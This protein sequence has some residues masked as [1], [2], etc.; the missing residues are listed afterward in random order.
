MRAMARAVTVPGNGGT[1]RPSLELSGPKLARALESLVFMVSLDIYLNE[2]SRHANVFLPGL[3][4]LEQPHCDDMIWAWAVRNAIKLSPA[5]FAP[6]LPVARA[7][8]EQDRDALGLASVGRA[9]H[10]PAR[11]DHLLDLRR[12]DDVGKRAE[13]PLGLVDRIEVRESGAENRGADVE[14]VAVGEPGA[15]GAGAAGEFGDG[16]AGMAL[17]ERV[18]L[19]ARHHA[20]DGIL[21]PFAGRHELR[22]AGKDRRAAEPRLLLDEDGALSD[23]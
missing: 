21:R 15:K 1:P 5:I 4:P 2:T 22:I 6:D 10:A 20:A 17:D 9:A 13:A 7:D 12:R 14:R 3:S 19:H 8:A 18:V 16:A 23:Y 11:R